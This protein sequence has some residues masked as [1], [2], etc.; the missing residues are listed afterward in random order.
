MTILTVIRPLVAVLAFVTAAG[1]G[2]PTGPAGAKGKVDD[3]QPWGRTFLST[4]VNRPLVE[5][6]RIRLDFHDDHRLGANAGCNHMGGDAEVA[7]DRLV[8]SDLA[9]T[10]MGCDPDRHRQD[11]WLAGFLTSRPHYRLDGPVLTLRN[12]STELRLEDRETADPDR[13][14]RGTRWVVEGVVEGDAVSSVPAGAEAHLVIDGAKDSFGGNA[15]CNQ[16]G[17]TARPSERTVT[18]SDV[19]TT[20]MA[21]QDDRMRLESAVLAVLDGEVTWKIEA[22]ALRLDHPNG[23]GL[24]LRAR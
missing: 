7:G 14:L 3:D 6:T 8:V 20:K 16:M 4:S 13:P 9:T 24:I 5:G 17:G 2:D 1:C 22:D 11:E 18:F 19:I 12:D 23:R 10:E 21:C 15:G